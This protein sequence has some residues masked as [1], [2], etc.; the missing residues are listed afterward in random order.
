MKFTYFLSTCSLLFLSSFI[1]CQSTLQVENVG[2]I[3]AIG[4][5]FGPN[6]Q[7]P[8]TA[9]IVEVNDGADSSDG[10]SPS[11]N[12]LSGKIVLISRGNCDFVAKALNAQA[13][14]A[15][16][17][18]ICNN[19]IANPN[20]LLFLTGNDTG[21]VNIPVKGIT[22]N[23]CNRIRTALTNGSVLATLF[24]AFNNLCAEALPIQPGTHQVDTIYADPVL[25]SLG[26][27]PS[28]PFDA[29]A[30]VW[31]SYT[32]ELD[33]IMTVSACEGGADTRLWV[34]T[35]SCDLARLDLITLIGS[36]D[37][38]PFELGNNEDLYASEASLPVQAGVTYWIEWDDK[39]ENTA[40]SFSLD[41]TPQTLTMERG[42]DC[43][44]AI[45][46]ETGI[47]E[48]DSISRFGQ[49]E[50]DNPY[51][52][53][54]FR[55]MPDETGL[56]SVTSCQGGSDTKVTLHEGSCENLIP[57]ARSSSGCAAFVNDTLAAR[58]DAIPVEAGKT[59]YIEWSGKDDQTGF[60]FEVSL[61][62]MQMIDVTFNVDM[63]FKNVANTS[64]NLFYNIPP[65]EDIKI[66]A[67]L[68]EN[69]DG[70]WSVTLPINVLDTVLY[71]FANGNEAE[72]VPIACKAEDQNFRKVIVNEG[73]QVSLETVCFGSCKPCSPIS[74]SEPR[75]I[76]K[77]DFD[78]YNLGII[79]N[80]SDRWTTWDGELEQEGIVTSERI[81]S[82]TKALK[83]AG[84][85]GDQDVLL[86]LDDRTEGHYSLT[87]KQFVPT[88]QRAYYNIQ[89]FQNDPGI[90]F[91]F[92][93][94]FNQDGTGSLDAGKIQAATFNFTQDEWID[95][96]HFIDLDEDVIRLYIDGAFVY[97]WKMN[98]AV[99][100]P[101]G[102]KSLGAVNFFP[103][104][105]EHLYYID[106][107]ELLEIPTAT[108]GLYAHTA[109]SIDVG[110]HAT[111]SLTCFGA[112]FNTQNTKGQSG[113]W[114]TYRPTE[115]GYIAINTCNLTNQNTRIWCFQ[116]SF[117]FN[118]QGVNDDQCSQQSY[119]EVPV[120]AN[121]I[122]Y[123]LFDNFHDSQSI[124]W[125]LSFFPAPLP[126]GDFCASAIPIDVGITT[127][128]TL[129]GQNV[130][131]GSSIGYEV[132]DFT[133]FS[134][135]EW[136]A[137]TAPADGFM[138]VFSCDRLP[139]ATKL[140]IYE[141]SC[142]FKHLQ[143]IASDENGCQDSTSVRDV[144]VEANRTYY[145]EWVSKSNERKGFDFQLDFFN[146]RVAIT[147][148]VNMEQLAADG[149]LSGQGAYLGGSFNDFE[150]QQMLDE[151]LDNIYTLS[152]NLFKGDTIQYRYYNG[153]FSDEDINTMFGEA[154][155][156]ANGNRQL[157]V[158]T[159]DTMVG[160]TC[161]GFCADCDIVSNTNHTFAKTDF[162]IF[163]NPTTNMLTIQFVEIYDEELEINLL[164]PFGR[165]IKQQKSNLQTT[166]FDLS[167][168]EKG[169]YFIQLK[170]GNKTIIRK[171]VVQ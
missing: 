68:D 37:A 64:V 63:N 104:Q 151:D 166:V 42:Q 1:F 138:D 41:F 125:E 116:D 59:Y 128:D 43:S 75:A 27:A 143:L 90:E 45:E 18:I 32:P 30:A 154:C 158:G 14:G 40:F 137:Y 95:V 170:Q 4:A 124:D 6:V 24:P 148:Q 5:L 23:D 71:V 106:D 82:G 108:E 112:N 39:W 29:S 162:N 149:S 115:D 157:I 87:W 150:T 44:S 144:A 111:P 22:L 164:N 114:Y 153:P 19:D 8:I 26:G 89:K 73:S 9:E 77:E 69:E 74:C 34:H 102:T 156:D 81:F 80:Q 36:D 121:T 50:L 135:S 17:V 48:L 78:N 117:Q 58:L 142:S 147:F 76:V 56:L 25:N 131:A 62:T 93:V 92:Q 3:Y 127:I 105:G 165:I 61:S 79:G 169:V 97:A 31:F 167:K 46:I 33:G 129:N 21:Q 152:L 103:A 130:V 132:E 10:C 52:S 133:L 100:E 28:H 107:I 126:E 66:A 120:K 159:Q 168:L 7:T 91:A 94:Q 15:V 57:I 60:L 110:N 53:E 96:Q 86:L 101:S 146:P 161:F 55:F 20:L 88:G 171:V 109:E 67:L 139:D 119:L 83:I 99:F 160:L 2:N 155:F 38:C 140:Y 51:G 35:G 84:N 47:F 70:I 11:V 49:T 134:S 12:D 65:Q 145:I 13:A 136:F 141:G 123:L 85:N 122:Y 98:F 16:A 72:S 118:I 113:Y 54:W 163:P